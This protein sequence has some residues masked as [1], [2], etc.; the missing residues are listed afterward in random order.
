MEEIK[1][2]GKNLVEKVDEL[3]NLLNKPKKERKKVLKVIRKAKVT[4]SRKKKGY[5]GVIKITENGNIS[6]EKVK[7]SDFVYRFKKGNYHVTD[8]GEKLWWNGKYPILLQQ[9]WKLN[10]IDLRKKEGE[11]N[12]V[13][14][15]K[16]VMARMMKDL[17]KTKSKSGNM[18]MWILLAVAAF[19]GYKLITGGL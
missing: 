13:Y 6:G 19:I 8:G 14:G 9:T 10:P 17:I 11:K 3:S 12:E 16:Y 15:Q 5:I 2:E 18:I 4:R 1:T 7:I